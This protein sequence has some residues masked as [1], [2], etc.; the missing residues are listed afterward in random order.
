M[1][2]IKLKDDVPFQNI[3]KFGFEEDFANCEDPRDH[4]YHLNNYYCQVNKEF[5]ITVN[6]NS[7]RID[8]LCLPS[9]VGVHNI[10]NIKPLYDLISNGLVESVK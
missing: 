6:M 10:S 3:A 4:Y 8:I 7:R 9:D 5:R 2:F 1:E